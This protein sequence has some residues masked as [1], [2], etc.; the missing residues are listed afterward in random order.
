MMNQDLS[1]SEENQLE[2]LLDRRIR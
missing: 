2:I 1:L